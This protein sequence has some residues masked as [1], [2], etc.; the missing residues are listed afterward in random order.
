MESPDFK[1]L[2]QEI[3]NLLALPFG[4]TADWAT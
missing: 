4:F 3:G 2:N 1:V